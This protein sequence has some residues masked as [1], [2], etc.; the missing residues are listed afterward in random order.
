MVRLL[1]TSSMPWKGQ[2]VRPT[3]REILRAA[4]VPWRAFHQIFMSGP[5]RFERTGCSVRG[6]HRHSFSLRHSV[7]FPGGTTRRNGYSAGGRSNQRLGGGHGRARG[8]AMNDAALQ[9]LAGI[10]ASEGTGVVDEPRR[11]GALLADRCAEYRLE[12]NLLTAALEEGVPEAILRGSEGT[13]SIVTFERLTR[14]LESGRGFDTD[15]ALGGQRLGL[16]ARRRAQ[17]CRTGRRRAR[18]HG[19]GGAP[20]GKSGRLGRD[21]GCACRPARRRPARKRTSRTA[22]GCART[23]RGSS[24]PAQRP[25][26]R[27]GCAPPDHRR[28][29]RV[30]RRRQEG[31]AESCGEIFLQPAAA[32]GPRPYTPSVATATPT[33]TP[34]AAPSPVPS[35]TG[36]TVA[37]Q[38][39]S[40]ATPGL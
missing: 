36:G 3:G 17:R 38:G 8:R 7:G 4:R 22:G 31:V 16:G 27:S 29:R 23:S 12:L 14:Q 28:R 24:L 35:A 34:P 39:E 20:A 33:V 26:R 30:Q 18:R 11:L 2:P 40:G 15:K 13:P 10:I 32:I 25:D 19:G 21:V 37:V 9:A 1:C 6:G 5:R